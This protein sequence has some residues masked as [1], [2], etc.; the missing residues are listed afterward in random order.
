MASRVGKKKK[1]KSVTVLTRLLFIF[2]F[3]FLQG[4][5]YCFV[6]NIDNLGA[7]VDVFILELLMSSRSSPREYVIEITDKTRADV[8][9]AARELLTI[10]G[11][12]F[13]G[14]N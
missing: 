2:V 7:T 10:F 14:W 1:K 5:E 4:F 12:C 11:H 3:S 9:V 6:S 8:K 13:A